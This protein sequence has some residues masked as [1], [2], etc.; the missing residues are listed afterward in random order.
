MSQRE[1][2]R[3]KKN[4]Q[5]TKRADGNKWGERVLAKLEALKDGDNDGN[6][7]SKEHKKSQE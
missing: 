3:L 7:E 4:K 1:Q 2:N 6:I 5:F